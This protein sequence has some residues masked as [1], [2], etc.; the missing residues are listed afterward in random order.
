M[1]LQRLNRLQQE[2]LKL[3]INN[4]TKII[5]E[6]KEI[7]NSEPKRIA[8]FKQEQ[9]EIKTKFK[10]NRLSKI[11]KNT[12]EINL[13]QLIKK[14]YLIIV[15]SEN[16]YIKALKTNVINIQH[17]GGKGKNI[18]DKNFNIKLS[19]SA[20][21]LDECL[22]FSSLGKVY[23]IKA[24]Q[25]PNYISNYSKGIPLNN[26]IKG[27]KE[28]E[29][30]QK[31]ISI[32]YKKNFAFKYIYLISAKGKI[33]KTR[34]SAFK[35][36]NKNGKKAIILEKDDY[37]VDCF[38][39]ENKNNVGVITKK[40]QIIKFLESEVRKTGRV[41]K[42]VRSIKLGKNDLVISAFSDFE[43]ASKNKTSFLAMVSERGIGKKINF[44]NIFKKHRYIKG[45]KAIKLNTKTQNLKFCRL[46]DETFDLL[47]FTKQ[48]K[49]IRIN[50]QQI[51][52]L[53]RY[54]SGVKLINLAKNDK[55]QY[56]GRIQKNI[57]NN[58]SKKNEQIHQKAIKI[59]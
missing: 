40:G 47:V 9:A 50:Y 28:N 41:G 44:D 16:S 6:L 15:L 12:F 4:I 58:N 52:L 18:I 54:S 45:V 49:I 59:D 38:V 20:F 29:K 33:K 55:V 2:K 5:V 8:I 56:V 25:V 11:V 30:I 57:V 32:N 39:S 34:L 42:G 19:T 31:I 43:A 35:Q 36:I 23:K 22:F 26:I 14:E 53:K 24:Y 7:I 17:R 48:G 1:Q 10:T 21:S 3:E 46:I 37:L 13:D 51:P 27:L